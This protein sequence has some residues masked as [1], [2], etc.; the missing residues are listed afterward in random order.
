MDPGFHVFDMLAKVL[1]GVSSYNL[2]SGFWLTHVNQDFIT[3]T[4]ALPSIY[5]ILRM[6]AWAVSCE[7]FIILDIICIN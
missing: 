7:F 5:L 1:W 6:T 3:R 2:T 4:I